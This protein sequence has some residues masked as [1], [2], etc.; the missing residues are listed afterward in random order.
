MPRTSLATVRAAALGFVIGNAVAIARRAR[1]S[2]AVPVSERLARGINIAIFALPPIAIV[3]V[4][5]IAIPGEAPRI[6][7]A[8]IAV[9]FPTMIAMT[10]GLARDR[11]AGGRPG[12]R[13]WRRQATR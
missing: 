8:A 11:S 13:L 5:V 1:S 9:Y 10:V 7:L 6:V 12:P 3:P 4:L 2:S